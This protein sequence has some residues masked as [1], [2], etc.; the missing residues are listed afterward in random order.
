MVDKN[1]LHKFSI[2]NVD[3]DFVPNFVETV[4]TVI[5]PYLKPLTGD[6]AFKW[7]SGCKEEFI[8]NKFNDKYSYLNSN[9][10]SST[11]NVQNPVQ[12]YIPL[13]FFFCRNAG[14]AI[15]LIASQYDDVKIKTMFRKM[16]FLINSSVSRLCS[17]SK[18]SIV[19]SGNIL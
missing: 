1:I 13:K 6:K 19:L 17:P 16:D 15:P 10:I 2:I 9:I 8:T 11:V 5:V 3:N 12:L 18:F 14:L 4:P 7:I